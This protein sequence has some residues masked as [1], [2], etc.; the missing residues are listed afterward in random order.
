MFLGDVLDDGLADGRDRVVPVAGS[1]THRGEG[2]DVDAQGLCIADEVGL[3]Q[4][5]VNLDLEDGGLNPGVAHDISDPLAVEVRQAD[6]L[7]KPRIVQGLHGLPGLLDRD[8]DQLHLRV[9]R[10]GVVEP[11]GRVPLLEG[12]ELQ[13]DRKVDQ[14]IVEVI[15]AE[16][17][18]RPLAGSLD[19]LGLVEGVP[20]L[21]RH[22]EVLAFDDPSIN[23]PLD[24]LSNLFLVAIVGSTI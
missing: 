14:V 19:M 22:P 5:R 9:G 17:G 8:V 2:G 13:R 3:L 11:L 10:V 7:H 15:E 20:Q 21:A 12:D 18:Q 24:A 16:V 1:M 6:V 4:V 23:G